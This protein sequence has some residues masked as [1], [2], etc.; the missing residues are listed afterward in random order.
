MSNSYIQFIL[1]FLWHHKL[2]KYIFI[3]IVLSIYSTVQP[4]NFYGHIVIASD[5][6]PQVFLKS[7]CMCPCQNIALTSK[8]KRQFIL[9]PNEWP[10]PNPQ[11]QGPSNAI[12]QCGNSFMKFF[13]EQERTKGSDKPRHFPDT[14]VGTSDRQGFQQ[15]WGWGV[16]V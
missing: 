16:I 13:C 9:E 2:G 4:L 15:S 11:R 6:M 5:W 7:L 1:L 12:F 10:W 8:G 3:D 14:L